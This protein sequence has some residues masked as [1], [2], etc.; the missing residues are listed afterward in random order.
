MNTLFI[1]IA[2]FLVSISCLPSGAP[3]CVYPDP[4]AMSPGRAG[5]GGFTFNIYP[6]GTTSNSVSSVTGGSK[7]TIQIVN[8]NSTYGGFLCVAVSGSTPSISGPVVGTFSFSGSDNTDLQT[9][10]SC[11]GATHTGTRST[12]SNYRSTDQ[13]T[14]TAPASLSTG[15][16]TFQ[17]VGVYSAAQWYGQSN[18]ITFAVAY[19]APVTTTSAT[20]TGVSTGS[21]AT[22]G[23][24]TGSGAT[25][26][27]VQWF[28]LV[29][30]MFVL[31]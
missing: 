25:H 8:N 5:A 22:T 30:L 28:L 12:P 11:G 10:Q 18:P 31:F 29:A 3:N 6:Y 9:V 23:K 21:V 26:V 17:V 24:T 15:T 7:Y 27:V 19:A 20:T 1:F 13:F 14:W 2:C 16:V 4:N